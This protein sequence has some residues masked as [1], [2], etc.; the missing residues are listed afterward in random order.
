[1]K[2]LKDDANSNGGARSLWQEGKVASARSAAR[3][4]AGARRR[5]AT[6]SAVPA[7]PDVQPDAPASAP[8]SGTPPPGGPRA[9]APANGAPTESGDRHAVLQRTLERY[10]WARLSDDSGN[11]LEL[12]L[13]LE[14][15][16]EN[17]RAWMVSMPEQ[18]RLPGPMEADLYVALGQLYNSQVPKDARAKQRVIRTTIGELAAITGRERG[19]TTYKALRA[20]LERL[21]DVAI[22]RVRTRA[23]GQIR[24]DE[25]RFHLFERVKY[26]H[27]RNG[28]TGATGVEVT[29]SDGLAESIANGEYRLLNATAYFA[30][31]T[32]TAKRLYRYLDYRRWRG[33][34]RQPTFSITLAQL[35][36]E[37]PVDRTSPS[38]IKRTLDPAHAQLVACGFLREAVYEDRPIA[39]KKR[40]QI[41]VRYAFGDTPA[42]AAAAL[43]PGPVPASLAGAAPKSADSRDDPNYVRDM[44]AEILG[45]LRDDHSMAF[46]VKVVRTL[47]E[48]LLRHVFGGVRQAIREGLPLEAARKTFTASARAQAKAAGLTL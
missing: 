23:D 14:A 24:A 45:T 31:E 38:H 11:Q 28:D 16:G 46:Y 2:P 12:K 25:E 18:Q 40:A 37:L 6:P 43:L 26:S 9:S 30:L 15:A 32:P 17:G 22:R 48:E 7:S 39:G 19:G 4:T 41:W 1:M 34:D 44:V 27:L 20:G 42:D 29:L 5:T 35:A 36:A 8:T 3:P 10:P 13:L 21:Q 47:P 33:E